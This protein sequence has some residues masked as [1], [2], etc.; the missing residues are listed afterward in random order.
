MISNL[1]YI[2]RVEQNLNSDL[3]SL[4][5]DKLLSVLSLLSLFSHRVVKDVQEVIL[6]ERASR[7]KC[8][9]GM[10]KPPDLTVQT[11]QECLYDWWLMLKALEGRLGLKTR[12]LK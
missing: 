6:S 5:Q 8:T 7:R 10:K 1:Q 4:Y 12:V 3:G 9:M 11:S 2:L